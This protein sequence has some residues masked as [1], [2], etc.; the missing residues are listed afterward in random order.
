M[1]LVF[2]GQIKCFKL[3]QAQKLVPENL[4]FSNHKKTFFLHNF[5]DKQNPVM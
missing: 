2:V 5:P 4:T 3:S 1:A